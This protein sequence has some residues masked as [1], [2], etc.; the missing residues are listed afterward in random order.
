MDWIQKAS[1]LLLWVCFYMCI[2]KRQLMKTPIV[3]ALAAVLGL[4]AMTAEA[5]DVSLS[6]FGTLGY[7]QSNQSYNYQRFINSN[8]TIQRDSV[9]GVQA[10]IKFTDQIGATVQGKFAPSLK[11][12]SSWDS[13]LTWAFLSWRPS[14][15]L[16]IRLGKQRV[17]LYLYSESMDVGQT[18]DFARLPTEMYSL[19]PTTDYIGASF[20][21]TW[22]P[23]LGELTL[24]GFAGNNNTDW[25]VYQRDSLPGVRPQGANFLTVNMQT[26]GLVLTLLRDEDK[27]RVNINKTTVTA[28]PSWTFTLYDFL[29]PGTGFGLPPGTTSGTAYTGSL[30]QAQVD[31]LSSLVFTLG[32]E[33]HLPKNFR[34]IGEYSRRE[35]PEA[36]NGVNSNGGYLALLRDVGAWTPY[37]S[38][39][40]IKSRSDVLSNYQSINGN[41]GL[42]A[43]VPIPAVV[44]GVAVV[45]ASQRV[46]ADYRSAVDQ[47]TIALGTSYRLTPTQKLKFEWARTHVGVVSSFVDAPSGGN[48]SNQNIDVLSFSYNVAF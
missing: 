30:P 41:P 11:S 38:C 47:S 10:D 9:V 42:T 35:V 27:Y 18:Y 6:G 5:A 3:W 48:V 12:D 15:D 23:D 25:R 39:A 21:K 40:M 22:N 7:A 28:D 44:A 24:D 19:A 13:T 20:S 29:I 2:K 4:F 1:N 31:K 32:A 46:L 33:I 43:L 45:N 17:P 26:R 36:M 8:G 37:V 14:D 16:L 34:V